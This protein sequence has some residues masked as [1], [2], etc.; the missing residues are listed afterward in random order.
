[1]CESE[2]N[3]EKHTDKAKRRYSRVASEGGE[4]ER[5]ENRGREE[6]VV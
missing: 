2:N 6:C 3:V 1:M 5:A 4:R